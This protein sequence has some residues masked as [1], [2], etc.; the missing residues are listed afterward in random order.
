MI[1]I[2]DGAMRANDTIDDAIDNAMVPA[3]DLIRLST[4]MARRPMS[5][6]MG[7][8]IADVLSLYC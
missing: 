8:T 3:F 1:R 6:V 2:D 5:K 4:M 7:M